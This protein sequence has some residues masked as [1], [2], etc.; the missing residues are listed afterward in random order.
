MKENERNKII[1]IK[2][3]RFCLVEG[4]I[5]YYLKTEQD[6][7]QEMNKHTYVCVGVT[8]SHKTKHCVDHASSSTTS[9]SVVSLVIDAH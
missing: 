1:S 3:N 4:K 7:E 8:F 9:Y 2:L 6:K 5:Y